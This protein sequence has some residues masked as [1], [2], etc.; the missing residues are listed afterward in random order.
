M[1][2]FVQAIALCYLKKKNLL[3]NKPFYAKNAEVE[4][5]G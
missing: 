2:H 4:G 1:K 5:K 3:V